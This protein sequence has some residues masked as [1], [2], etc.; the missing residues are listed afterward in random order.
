MRQRRKPNKKGMEMSLN[1]LVTIIIA[2]AIFMFG[3]RFIYN[4]A[5]SANELEG[6]S[7]DQLDSRIG[8]LLCDSTDRVCIG[9]DKKTIQKGKFDV[10]GI[11][12]VNIQDAKDFDVVIT[13]PT[14]SGYTVNKQ[15]IVT[16]ELDWK[17]RQRTIHLERNE[18]KEVG[19]GIEVPKDTKAGTY[20]FDVRVA[21]YNTLNKRYVVVP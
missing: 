12:V 18:E 20:I 21:P 14:P 13:R 9:I 15:D 1:F 19:V 11:K 6:I 7:V 8:S 16:D 2:L 17:P 3:I 4:L 10:F 5:S